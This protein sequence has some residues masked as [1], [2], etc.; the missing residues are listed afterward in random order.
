MA[1][2]NRDS[3]NQ[4]PAYNNSEGPSQMSTDGIVA[5]LQ[6]G[7]DQQLTFPLWPSPVYCLL[8]V[9]ED[10]NIIDRN[11]NMILN[12]I[13]LIKSGNVFETFDNGWTLK[14]FDK[15]H[16][17]DRQSPQQLVLH[18]F[19]TPP[20]QESFQKLMGQVRRKEIFDYIPHLHAATEGEVMVQL[21]KCN[22]SRILSTNFLE[23]G[24]SYN[25]VLI[26]GGK[27]PIVW[28]MW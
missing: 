23:R 1:L 26:N 24:L 13:R 10:Q 16:S 18:R 9:Y 14:P 7:I 12:R 6:T 27:G 15:R 25:Y 21:E 11:M 4:A 5:T 2:L 28:R 19:G 20:S 3:L 17:Q 8:D 22:L